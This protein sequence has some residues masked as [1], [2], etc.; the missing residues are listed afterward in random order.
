MI[1]AQASK[2]A[3]FH[4]YLHLLDGSMEENNFKHLNRENILGKKEKKISLLE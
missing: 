2:E 4:L 1:Q 3:I